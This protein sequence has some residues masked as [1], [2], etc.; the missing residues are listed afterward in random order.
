MMKLEA[1][2]NEEDDKSHLAI[3]EL[4]KEAFPSEAEASLVELLRKRNQIA[5]SQVA[6]SNQ[7]VIGYVVLSK[8][9]LDPDN[10][11]KCLGLGPIAVAK[12]FQGRGIGSKLMKAAIQK[13]QLMGIDA[14]F[15]LGDPKY[16]SRFG[17]QQTTVGN[18]YGVVE[19]FQV[20]ELTS[21]CLQNVKAKAHYLPAFS[22]IDV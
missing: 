3:H 2:I 5:V 22:E 10:G 12:E 11:L 7:N 8:V 18:D 20:L 21:G 19:E 9:M 1:T 4:L 15:L 16:Y 6:V 14:I 13:C 17:F